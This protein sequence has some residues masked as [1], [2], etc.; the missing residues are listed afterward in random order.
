LLPWDAVSD[1]FKVQVLTA[2][3]LLAA[4]ICLMYFLMF[5]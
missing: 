5:R 1:Y 3:P 4:N 2:L